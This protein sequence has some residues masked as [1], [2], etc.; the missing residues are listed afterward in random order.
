MSLEELFRGATSRAGVVR[1]RNVLNPLLWATVTASPICFAAAYVFE[2][3]PV[4]RYGL[5]V[6]G[7]L[8][9][10]C[11]LACYLY[12]ML[13]Q[14]DRLQSE[15][16]ITR[17]EELR[18]IERKSGPPIPAAQSDPV[19]RTQMLQNRQRELGS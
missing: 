3:D 6:L 12:W 11:T 1:V 4:L 19:D 7:A 5:A 17:Q 15:E 10:L 16:F 18:I 14:P 2:A 8:P 9:I 13:H